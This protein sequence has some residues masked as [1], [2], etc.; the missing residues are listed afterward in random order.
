MPRISVV[1]ATYNASDFVSETIN[2]ILR[3]TYSDFELIIVDDASRDDTIDRISAFRDKRI[4]LIRNPSNVGVASARNIGVDAATGEYLVANDHDDI[5]LPRRLETQVAFLDRSAEVLMVGTGIYNERN[6][7][8][9]AEPLPPANHPVLRWCLMTHSP[10]CHSTMCVRLADMRRA[11]LRY[12]S[13]W[14]FGDDFD[15]Y[16]RMAAAGRLASVQARLVVYRF[17]GNNASIAREAEMMSRGASMLARAHESYL[18]LRLES[19]E[20]EALWRVF[21]MF[22]PSRSRKELQT[23]GQ[24]LTSLLGRYLEV[25][26]LSIEERRQVQK[27]A[28]QQWWRAVSRAVATLGESALSEFNRMAAL[29]VFPP[30][31]PLRLRDGLSRHVRRLLPTT[32]R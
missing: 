20:F 21:A 25:M 27:F 1:M 30:S 23:A 15:L 22:S 29:A 18:G 4:R 11:G 12:D 28:S 9:T 7:M 17:H 5:S 19:A 3:Q 8:R 32:A 2:A 14:D 13:S 24:A 16:H 10:I 26:E 31:I 6:G